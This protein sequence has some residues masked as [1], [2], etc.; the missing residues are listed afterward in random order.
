[1]AI[2]LHKYLSAGIKTILRYKDT[3][4]SLHRKIFMQFLFSAVF[5]I[6]T[7]T[8]QKGSRYLTGIDLFSYPN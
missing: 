8:S 7:C 2:P 6:L 5:V 1:M 3:L 4:Y